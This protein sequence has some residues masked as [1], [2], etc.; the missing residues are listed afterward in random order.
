MNIDRLMSSKYIPSMREAKKRYR[1]NYKNYGILLF[2]PV[3]SKEEKSSLKRK[4][5]ILVNCIKKS[6]L[7]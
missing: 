3:V 1:I 5:N 7:H 4:I 2:H 6:K